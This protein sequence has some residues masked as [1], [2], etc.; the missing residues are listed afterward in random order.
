MHTNVVTRH[1]TSFPIEICLEDFFFLQCTLMHYY[2]GIPFF[3]H[4]VSFPIKFKDGG[5][6][7]L[8][9]KTTFF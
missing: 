7:V 8:C 3:L 1:S 4:Y 5:I 6:L 9:F 2:L